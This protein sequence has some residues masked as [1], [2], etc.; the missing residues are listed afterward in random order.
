M[1]SSSTS[2]WFAVSLRH[3]P[4]LPCSL[5]RVHEV[6]LTKAASSLVLAGLPSSNQLLQEDVERVCDAHGPRMNGGQKRINI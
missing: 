4:S 1:L 6:L 2:G 5:T 3:W